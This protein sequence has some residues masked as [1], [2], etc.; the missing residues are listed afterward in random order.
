MPAR[1]P[2]LAASAGV[3]LGRTAALLAQTSKLREKVKRTARLLKRLKR[4]L[5]LVEQDYFV[6]LCDRAQGVRG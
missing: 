4:E 6:A 3:E 1:K 2:K 5:K